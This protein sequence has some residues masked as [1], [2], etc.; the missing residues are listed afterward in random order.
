[1]FSCLGIISTHSSAK[2]LPMFPN[3]ATRRCDLCV[4]ECMYNVRLYVYVCV[5]AEYVS[6]VRDIIICITLS[7]TLCYLNA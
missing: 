5:C 7:F 3:D 2:F 1:M 4:Y 6:L